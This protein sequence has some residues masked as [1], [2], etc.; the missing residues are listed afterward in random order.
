MYAATFAKAASAMWW[1]LFSI[2]AHSR[3]SLHP[4]RQTVIVTMLCQHF[5][6]YTQPP[7]PGRIPLLFDPLVYRSPLFNVSPSLCEAHVMALMKYI[8]Y[9][10]PQTCNSPHLNT[11]AYTQAHWNTGVHMTRTWPKNPHVLNRPAIEFPQK[12]KPCTASNHETQ[13]C[14]FCVRPPTV[15]SNPMEKY[16]R[17]F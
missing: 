14:K 5:H 9:P 8:H 4:W 10:M 11:F 3:S 12:D 17:T 13:E 1:M 7:A 2:L 6:V 15:A 16:S